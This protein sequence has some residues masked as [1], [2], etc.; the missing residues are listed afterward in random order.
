MSNGVPTAPAISYNVLSVQ[1][2]CGSSQRRIQTWACVWW[3]V[4]ILKSF[5]HS[6]NRSTPGLKLTVLAAHTLH[7]SSWDANV[8]SK[9]PLPSEHRLHGSETFQIAWSFVNKSLEEYGLSPLLN[10]SLPQRLV[11]Q[12]SNPRR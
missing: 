12:D 8:N 11:R 3:C 7:K 10:I 2:S 1:Y 9:N 4:W 6:N 5:S